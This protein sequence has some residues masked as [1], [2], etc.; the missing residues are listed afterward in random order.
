MHYHSQ[1]HKVFTSQLLWDS[2]LNGIRWILAV[3][4]GSKIISNSKN[5]DLANEAHLA[6]L[7]HDIGKIILDGYIVEKK[8][9]IESFM[10]TKEKT[11][12]ETES[13]YFGFN[14]A[15]IASEVG[16]KW[17]FPDAINFA[18][19]Y[20]HQPGNS[21]GNEL[22]YIIH[23]ADYIAVLSGVGYDSDDILYKP[24]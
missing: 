17:N 3:A 22:S 13:Q 9:E 21:D 6:G 23:M 24:E 12:L 1:I 18:I 7:I 16:K 11:F 8:E 20:H 5:P 15:D 4:F 10:E 14:H 19:K 2:C